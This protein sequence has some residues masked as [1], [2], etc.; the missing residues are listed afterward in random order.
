MRS[1]CL[2]KLALPL[3]LLA[4][5]TRAGA[6][7]AEQRF[8]EG[9]AA[10]SRGD[11]SA[12]C[13]AFGASFDQSGSKGA[14]YNLAQCE[15][16]GHLG[17]LASALEHW[18]GVVE[19]Y[20]DKPD[21]RAEAEGRVAAL[22]QR[23]ALLTLR[24]APTF[25]A[26]AATALDGKA[27]GLD[28]PIPVDA[29]QHVVEVTLS[30]RPTKRFEIAL[31]DGDRKELT[32]SLD[33][34]ARPPAG[35][36]SGASTEPD[37]GARGSSSGLRTAAWIAGGAGVIGLGLFVVSLPVQASASGEIDDACG[38]D[39][40]RCTTADPIDAQSRGRTWQIVEGVGLGVGLLGLGLGT[41]FFILSSDDETTSVGF[42]GD[43]VRLRTT[44]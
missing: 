1:T 7:S 43:G 32:V 13:A 38:E 33:D 14:L 10:M 28:T 26:G 17:R 24:R 16:E 25:P 9:R 8:D 20:A 40:Q 31:A 39:R 35:P 27:A 30:G 15:D 4:T 23:V 41:T 22:A 29:G 36:G 19:R 5:T 37:G 11:Y 18:R 12:A 34:A 3:A 42:R 2:L 6:Q 21:I 44:F